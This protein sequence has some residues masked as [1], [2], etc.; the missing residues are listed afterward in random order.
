MDF[1]NRESATNLL[2]F[3]GINTGDDIQV[4]V[5]VDKSRAI[6]GNTLQYMSVVLAPF[7]LVVLICKYRSSETHVPP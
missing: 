3:W 6:G 4:S 7:V 5:A 2:Y 1:Q